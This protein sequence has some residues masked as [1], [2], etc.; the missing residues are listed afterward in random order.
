MAERHL[1]VID[2]SLR[3]WQRRELAMLLVKLSCDRQTKMKDKNSLREV[4]K[5][6]NMWHCLV[7]VISW[8]DNDVVN[9]VRLRN[10]WI[11]ML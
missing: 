3:D 5:K 10:G 7:F 2:V 11:T 1:D 4:H 6:R 9:S 8:L